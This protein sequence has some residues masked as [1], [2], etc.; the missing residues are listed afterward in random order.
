MLVK[1][2]ETAKAI[3][4]YQIVKET[5]DYDDWPYQALLENRIKNAKQNTA[6]FRAPL[7][8]GSSAYLDDNVMLINTSISCT[9]CH[10]KSQNELVRDRDF[11]YRAYMR[12]KDI[13]WLKK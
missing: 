3:K 7:K 12:D 6:K 4:V 11:D 5:P 2:G 8:R 13:Y 9:V 1:N 10:R